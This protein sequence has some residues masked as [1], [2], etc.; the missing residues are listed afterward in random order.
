[1]RPAWIAEVVSDSG[2]RSHPYKERLLSLSNSE[3]AGVLQV[4]AH[5]TRGPE[6][7]G[8]HVRGARS[9]ME[10]SGVSPSRA[11]FSHMAV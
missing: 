6:G 9:M 1:V 7:P 11:F 8:L 10:A 3:G 4:K 5:V 2:Q